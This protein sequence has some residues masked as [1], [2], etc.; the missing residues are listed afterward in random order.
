MSAQPYRA[1]TGGLIDRATTLSFSFDGRTYQGHPGDTLASALVANGVRLV[2]RSFKYHRPRGIFASG[3]EEPNALVELRTGARREPNTRATQIELYGGLVANSQNRWPS[4]DFDLMA[5]NGFAGPLIS[6]GFY[7]KTFMWPAAFWEKLYEPL[8]RR[9]AG[10]GRAAGVED[11]DRYEKATHHCDVLVIGSGPAGLM[12]ALTAGRSGARVLL[13][14][15]DFRLGGR[16][17]DE[18]QTIDDAPASAWL[19]AAEA[20]LESLPEVRI[21]RRTTLFGSYDQKAFVAVERVADHLPEPPPFLPRQRSWRIFA[22]RTVLTAGSI[23]RPIVFGDN[24][25]PGVML[26]GAVRSYIN[27]YAAKPGSSAV[28]FAGNDDAARTAADLVAAGVRVAAI[29]DPRPE[30]SSAMQAQAT[31]AGAELLAGSVVTRALGNKYGVQA[32]EIDGPAGSRTIDCDLVAVSSGWNPTI[33]IASHL[34]N[35]PT[36]NPQISAFVAHVMPEGMKAAG[37]AAG[38]FTLAAALSSGAASGAEAADATGFAARRTPAPRIE[39]EPSASTPLWRVRGTKGKAFV[40]YQHDVTAADVELAEREGF[41]AVEHLKRYTT[42]GM[43]TDQ[44]KTAN[45]TGLALMAEITGNDISRVGTTTFR[46]PFTP[47]AIGALG[48]HSRGKQFRPTRHSPTHRWAAANGAVFVEAG[49]WLRAQYFPQPGDDWLAA[50]LREAK[51]V[52]ERVGFCDVSTLGKIDV[53]GPD[54]ACFLDRLYANTISTLA[55]GKVRYGVMLREDGFVFDDGTV[56]RLSEAHWLVTTTTA[57]AARVLQHMEFCAQVLWPELDVRF[58]SVTDQWAQ[59]AVAGPRARDLLRGIVD[60]AHDISDATLPYMGNKAVTVCGGTA[61]HLYRISFSGEI[62]YE[63]AVPARFGDALMAAIAAAGKAHE[64]LPYGTEALSMLR[65]EK[66]HPAGSELNGQTTAR[67]LG[68]SKMVST[69]KDFVGRMLAQR[70]ALVDPA[71]PILVGFKPV[72][73]KERLAAGAH[74]VDVGAAPTTANDLGHMTSVT[75]S[76][77]LGHWIGLGLLSRGRERI[78]QSV[79]AHDPVRG[80]DVKVEVCDPVFHDPQGARLRG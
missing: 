53:Q 74:F 65:I 43:A 45:V 80:R 15:Q 48:G 11:P 75:L 14:E 6:A 22:K 38:E 47:V 18:R 71:R 49:Q 79:V 13:V 34:G 21:L 72:D 60:P 40:D 46:P 54:G 73:R 42:L 70:P 27:R 3:A 67:D 29:V 37:A 19:A 8:I 61:G 9:A 52:R 4:L 30:S 20:E 24:D 76:P 51:A 56:A 26:A 44:G 36:W 69:K 62:A 32:V 55:V 58:S 66:G 17:L 5:I 31:A 64:A 41:R 39:P 25:R 1:P 16:L 50:T 12:A 68:L 77:V 59:I 28:I 57:N 10:L 7:Y 23:E 33:H 2:G 63:L 35:K 78:G